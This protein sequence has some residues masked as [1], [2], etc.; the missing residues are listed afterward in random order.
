MK[1]LKIGY[2]SDTHLDFYVSQKDPNRMKQPIKNYIEKL[3]QPEKADVLI[4]AGDMTHYNMQLF[5]LVDQLRSSYDK[6]LIVEGNHDRYLVSNNVRDKYKKSSQARIDE[7]I[8]EY[9]DDNDVYFL[10]GD[11]VDIKGVK[12]GGYGN[13]YN[14]DTDGKIASWNDIMYDSN[15]IMEG[16]EPNRFTYGYGGS[17]K[18]SQWDTQAF[19]LEN[20]KMLENIIKEQCNIL[21]THIVPAVIPDEHLYSGHVGDGNNLFYMTDDIEEVQKTGADI[22]IYGHNHTC[23]EFDLEG[24]EFKTNALGYPNEL[25]GF[26]GINHFTYFTKDSN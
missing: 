1:E 8:N 26:D 23:I 20:E 19:R 16:A 24:I 4:I 21:V 11:V 14:L 3:L 15:L 2:L 10:A 9:K 13:W 7:V 17:H 18:A 6:F 25:T 12:F 22:V 5:E